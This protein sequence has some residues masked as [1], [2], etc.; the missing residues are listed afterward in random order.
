[1]VEPVVNTSPGILP[2]SRVPTNGNEMKFENFGIIGTEILFLRTGGILVM[3]NAIGTPKLL[4]N[5]S[6]VQLRWLVIG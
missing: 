3:L 5:G 2:T 1:M 6:V 4:V